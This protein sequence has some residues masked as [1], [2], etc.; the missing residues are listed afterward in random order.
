MNQQTQ[1]RP[2]TLSRLAVI[3]TA[4]IL[5]HLPGVFAHEPV[6]AQGAGMRAAAIGAG[7]GIVLAVVAG[8]WRWHWATTA[9]VAVLSYFAFGAVAAL[10]QTSP[11]GILPT[12]D[13]LTALVVQPANAWKDLLTLVPPAY[14]FI[15]PAVL[16]YFTGL[17][18]ALTAGFAAMRR[19]A[20]FT[21]VPPVIWYVIGAAWSVPYAP[22][23]LWLGIGLVAAVSGWLAVV[24]SWERTDLGTDVA[25][26]EAARAAAR[27]EGESIDSSAPGMQ[28]TVHAGMQRRRVVASPL[29]RAAAALGTIAVAGLVAALFAQAWLG[30][31]PRTVLRH[32]VAPPLVVQDLPTPL[33][34]FRHLSADLVDEPIMTVS[35]LPKDGRIRFAAMDH[36]D[37]VRWG[38][39]EP[40]SGRGFR[41]VGEVVSMS[42]AETKIP[43]ARDY[44]IT[45]DLQRPV[46]RWVPSLGHVEQVYLSDSAV[47]ASLFYDVDLQSA[48][49]AE[50]PTENM[51][52]EQ[53]G[54][55]EPGWSEAQL[56][57]LEF[58]NSPIRAPEQLPENLSSLATSVTATASSPID[59]VRSLERHF[60]DTGYYANGLEYPSAPGHNKNRISHL[61]DDEQMIGD[62]E[63]YA[64]AMALAAQS[65]GIPARVV[66]GAYPDGYSDTQMVLRGSDVHVWVEI[67]FEKVGWVPFDPTPPKDHTPQTELPEPKSVP[68]PQVLQ[69]PEPPKEPPQLPAEF[70]DRDIED[71]VQSGAPF[72]WF[73][74]GG[75]SL[76]LLLLLAPV[77]G[78]PLYKVWRRQ[79]RRRYRG[80]DGVRAAWYEAEDYAI[81]AGF[82]PNKTST[83]L[84]HAQLLETQRQLDGAA[85]ALASEV[86]AAEFSG[87]PVTD[88]EK[89]RAWE[90]ERR[91]RRALTPEG[92]WQ[93]YRV[94]ISWRTLRTRHR[95]NRADKPRRHPRDSKE[96]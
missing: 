78:V 64:T 35:G 52:I 30:N 4:L 63:Q 89:Q 84:E 54:W 9:G 65:L 66:V 77:L 86:G 79:R 60:R 7:L 92:L 49:A 48:V 26:G 69:P 72:P 45:L 61:I 14:P 18:S 2:L 40:D 22:N 83:V 15:G 13:T 96:R 38:I 46:S 11:D 44:A 93:R 67:E 12:I 39:S 10:P 75:G 8:H 91:L 87:Q 31:A 94:R 42:D 85:L 1:Q 41:Q 20:V 53:R 34:R 50:A 70:E 25:V 36:Y 27:N 74:V 68:R 56:S 33:E 71:P 62:D 76:L 3:V 23:A 5:L 51:R 82:V 19:R 37:G 88:T 90:A 58:G 59:R 81:D 95:R 21:T 29:R 47:A 55:V 73:T 80:R 28:T 43:A 17:V 57:G 24:A 16:P 6:F 32:Y